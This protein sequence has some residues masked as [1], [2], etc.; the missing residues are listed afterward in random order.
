MPENSYWSGG[1][2]GPEQLAMNAMGI[3]YGH[4]V[5]VG[6]EDYLWLDKTRKQPATNRRMVE[7]IIEL[8]KLLGREAATPEEVRKA[9]RL[10]SYG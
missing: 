9:L 6:L 2:V 8:A 5:R 7:R 1:A 4:G 3:L 10:P